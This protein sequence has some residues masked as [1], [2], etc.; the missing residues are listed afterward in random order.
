MREYIITKNDAN[1]RADRVLAKGAPD[2]PGSLLQKA[3]RKK[4]V[5]RNGRPCRPEDRLA[6]G[7]VLRLYGCDTAP[8]KAKSEAVPPLDASSIVYEDKHI[9]M[10]RKPGGIPSQKTD[11]EPGI[12]DMAREY[13]LQKKS[14]NPDKET[15]FAPSLCHRLD[16]NTEG[17]I[18]FAKSAEALQFLTEKIKR[19][20]IVKT[21]HCLV[22]GCPAPKAGEWQDFLWKDAQKKHVYI[23]P[24]HTP[25]AK[26]ALLR[27]KVLDNRGNRSL[28]EIELVTGRTHQIRVQ[29]AGRGHPI[30]GDG[31]YGTPIKNHPMALCAVKL[32]MAFTEEGT[33]GYLSG[34]VF[35]L[36]SPYCM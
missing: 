30:L 28:L 35:S 8:P 11:R 31:K 17:L 6:E 4:D 23:K 18:L 5:K 12:E 19:R 10:L 27:Y 15:G 22:E 33:L 3:F 36:K 24:P 2:L 13:L 34:K 20:E 21:Y 16:R 14:W 1:R 32:E 26:K 7:D 25:G 29:C 9:L